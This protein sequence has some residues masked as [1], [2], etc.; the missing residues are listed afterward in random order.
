MTASEIDRLRPVAALNEIIEQWLWAAA[1]GNLAR[2]RAAVDA[3]AAVAAKKQHSDNMTAELF[4]RIAGTGAITSEMESLRALNAHISRIAPGADY[5]EAVAARNWLAQEPWMH[6]ARCTLAHIHR[7]KC[8]IIAALERALAT[9]SALH[10]ACVAR[11][12]ANPGTVVWLECYKEFTG[13][14]KEAIR[15]T[16]GTRTLIR[17]R[18]Y[19]FQRKLNTKET[20]GGGDNSLVHGPQGQELMSRAW[21]AFCQELIAT[22][23]FSEQ[24][25]ADRS[26]GLRGWQNTLRVAHAADWSIVYIEGV[27]QHMKKID[28]LDKFKRWVVDQCRQPSAP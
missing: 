10:V 5:P 15:A 18:P 11:T 22:E 16:S 21:S 25:M 26:E 7:E 3:A 13:M 23:Q 12:V 28:T 19:L 24:L 27:L 1:A 20:P 2:L 14:V 8:E 4:T 17:E 6:V 9:V